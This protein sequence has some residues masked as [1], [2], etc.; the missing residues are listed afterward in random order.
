MHGHRRNL[1]AGF[2][3]IGTALLAITFAA[4]AEDWTPAEID[5]E[6]WLDADDASTITETGGAVSQWDDKSG[7][8]RHAT[9]ATG[10]KQP[11]YTSSDSML[12]GMPS[13]GTGGLASK[14][15]ATPEITAKRIYAVM[16]FGDGTETVF[17]EHCAPICGPGQWGT[18]RVT[19]GNAGSTWLNQTSQGAFNDAGT[20]RDGSTTSAT[21]ALPMPA[22]LPH[23]HVV[24]DSAGRQ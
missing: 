11:L 23:E 2:V 18:W 22:T 3:G 9:Q 12:G 19:G 16:Y 14:Y 10:S 20:Y 4:R 21:T 15:L 8:A 5:T 1:G 13:V 17:P 24:A 7:N 6:L